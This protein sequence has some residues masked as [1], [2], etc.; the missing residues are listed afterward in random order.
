[1]S[2]Y[3]KKEHLSWLVDAMLSEAKRTKSR[4]SVASYYR[5]VVN[6]YFGRYT[7]RAENSISHYLGTAGVYIDV[8]PFD[9]KYTI[10]QLEVIKFV[11]DRRHKNGY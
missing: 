8:N 11:L 5:P 4:V 7:K 3:I 9:N 1:M 6:E 2:K 10:G